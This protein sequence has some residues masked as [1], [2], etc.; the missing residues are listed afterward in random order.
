MLDKIELMGRNCVEKHGALSL[1]IFFLRQTK[2]RNYFTTSDK[3]W[4]NLN[5]GWVPQ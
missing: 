1:W 2:A 4:Q 3:P 5:V